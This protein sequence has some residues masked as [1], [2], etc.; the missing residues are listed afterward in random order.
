MYQKRQLEKKKLVP[1]EIA[2]NFAGFPTNNKLRKLV[3]V[4][5]IPTKIYSSYL[6]IEKR[7]QQPFSLHCTVRNK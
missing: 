6:T 1:D 2:A 5:Y 3:P 7:K 4:K